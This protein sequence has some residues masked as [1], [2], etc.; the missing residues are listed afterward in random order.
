M[1]STFFCLDLNWVLLE[2]GGEALDAYGDDHGKGIAWRVRVEEEPYSLEA[3][4]ELRG[5]E[6]VRTGRGSN[7]TGEAGHCGMDCKKTAVHKVLI[8]LCWNSSNK[9]GLWMHL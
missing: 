3:P 5:K 2:K 8:S 9:A 7:F 1:G 6:R 4:T